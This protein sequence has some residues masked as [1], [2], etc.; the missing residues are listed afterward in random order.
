MKPLRIAITLTVLGLSLSWAQ[1]DVTRTTSSSQEQE[2]LELSK[3]K[4]G[5]M[6]EKDLEP[7]SDLFHENAK[8][9]HMSGTW[10]TPAELDIIRTGR[11]WYKQADVHDVV[12]EIFGD[13]A[14]AWNRITLV[15]EVG[16]NEVSNEFT[17]TEVYQNLEGRWKLIDMTF[18]SVR[19]SH[20]IAQ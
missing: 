17:V 18:S 11:I 6:A 14:I 1:S 15:A 8:F 9:V 13:T 2:I 4:W 16:G 20:R 12:V 7:L 19:D 5:W 3:A 10:N